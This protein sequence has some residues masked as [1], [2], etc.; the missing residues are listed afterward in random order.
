MNII[1]TIQKNLGFNALVKIDPNTQD[2]PDAGIVIG[3]DAIAQ[4]GIPAILLG[5]YNRLE[6]DPDLR[7]L[8]AEPQGS[9]LEQVFG[10]STEVVVK[11]IYDYSRIQDKHSVQQLEHIAAE[12]MRVVKEKIGESANETVIRNFV[13]RNKPDTLL[14]LPPSLDLGTILKNDNLDDR[15]GKME[16]PISSLMHSVEKAF[17]TSGS[18]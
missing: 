16:G 6:S 1:E 12:S 8:D 10:K 3:N 2:T 9:C 5:I 13:A 17:N 14:Y 4:A 11:R 15:T 7:L 18:N